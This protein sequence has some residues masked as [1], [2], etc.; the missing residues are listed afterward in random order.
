MSGIDVVDKP[1]T[2]RVAKGAH[3]VRSPSRSLVRTRRVNAYTGGQLS[4]TD[5]TGMHVVLST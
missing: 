5:G 4:W 2:L 1:A 3:S